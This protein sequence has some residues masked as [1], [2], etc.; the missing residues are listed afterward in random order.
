MARTKNYLN[1]YF[2]RANNFL[3]SLELTFAL[4]NVDETATHLQTDNEQVRQ[5]AS[6][7]INWLSNNVF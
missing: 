2:Y 3:I 6:F 1:S 5:I 7:D 4:D